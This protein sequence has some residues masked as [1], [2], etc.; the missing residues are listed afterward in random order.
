MLFGKKV[1]YL[2]GLVGLVVTTGLPSPSNSINHP[3]TSNDRVSIPGVLAGPAGSDINEVKTPVLS[4]EFFVYLP[5]GIKGLP[6]G[7]M[8]L[9]PAGSFQMGCDQAHNGGY[10]CSA[11]ELPLHS[12]TLGAYFIDK[13]EVTNL[14]YQQCVAA[15]NCRTPYSNSSYSRPS[16]YNNTAYDNYPVI[17]ISWY[18]ATDYCAWSGK[19]LPTEAEWEKAARGPND[20]RAYPWGDQ[21]PDCTMANFRQGSYCE[22]DTRPVD[23]YPTGASPYGVMNMAGNMWEWVNDWYQSDYYN[24]TPGSN[25]PGPASGDY[26]VF[27]G[28]SFSSIIDQLRVSY[29]SYYEPFDR[30]YIGF[31]C[32]SSSGN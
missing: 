22:G 25:T 24:Q 5:I 15:G 10:A 28:G 20:T 19:R 3:V 30:W 6:S 17:F 12:V 26:K 29:R 27:R 4:N 14:D 23:S 32:A 2:I 1:I 8:V 18:D 11:D 9:I 16:Y 7:D 13:H 31:R 21:D